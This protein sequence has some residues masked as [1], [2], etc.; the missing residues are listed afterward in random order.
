MVGREISPSPGG[1]TK[2]EQEIT[3]PK[4]DEVEQEISPPIG[5]KMKGE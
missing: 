1:M 3:P 5:G 4:G 2:D